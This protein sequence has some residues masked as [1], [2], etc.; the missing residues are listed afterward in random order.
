MPIKCSIGYIAGFLTIIVGGFNKPGILNTLTLVGGN[1][2][3]HTLA[4]LGIV[5]ELYF[6]V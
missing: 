5:I 6:V 3:Y 1:S 2:E 4:N